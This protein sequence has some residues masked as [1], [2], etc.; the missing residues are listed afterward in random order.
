MGQPKKRK[1]PGEM[2]EVL[3]QNINRLMDQRY[4]DS[5]NRPM[6]LAKDA[7]VSLSSVQR[8]L[9]RETGASIDTVE[10][11]ARVFGLPPFQL[12]VPWGLLGEIAA[13]AQRAPVPRQPLF[14]GSKRVAK[15]PRSQKRKRETGG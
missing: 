9:S 10:S 8:T 2:R 5:A 1:T 15:R 12:L 11:F 13:G 14:A 4:R 3:A 6:A 7:Q